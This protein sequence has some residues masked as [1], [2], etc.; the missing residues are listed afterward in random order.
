MNEEPQGRR[1][2]GGRASDRGAGQDR[3]AQKRQAIMLAAAQ[4]FLERGYDGTSMDNIASQ[5]GVS[6]PTVY[7]HFPDK[8][9]LFVAIVLDTLD[10]IGDP[11]RAELAELART[12]NLAQDLEA[13]A[14]RYLATVLSSEVLRLRRLVIGEAG[15]QPQLAETYYARSVDRTLTALAACF[16]Q[17]GGRGLLEIADP[18][19][20]AG[21]FAFL[22]LSRP[23]DRALFSPNATFPEG[24]IEAQARAGVHAF[25]RAYAERSL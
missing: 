16:E 5:A 15:R 19:I 6:K 10:R 2:Q 3:S 21:H 7:N 14:R 24:A 23:L 17:L 12:E 11:I 20:A 18:H 22:V 8:E 9:Q 4:L 25:L 1:A 13:L